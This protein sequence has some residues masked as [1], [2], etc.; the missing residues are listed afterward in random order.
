[1]QISAYL[2]TLWARDS[3]FGQFALSLWDGDSG[4]IA[5]DVVSLDKDSECRVSLSSQAGD[6]ELGICYCLFPQGPEA[7][8][9]GVSVIV[10]LDGR[11][12]KVCLLLCVSYYAGRVLKTLVICFCLSPNRTE[13]QNK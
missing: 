7:Q 8:N 3:E 5:T 12:G 2:L 6:S 4:R 9:V 13:T 1:M 11:L 10:S